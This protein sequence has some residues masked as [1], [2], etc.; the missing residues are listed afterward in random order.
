M[1][2]YIYPGVYIEEVPLWIKPIAGVDTS[3]TGFAGISADIAD[4]DTPEKSAGNFSHVN[5]LVPQPINI[6]QEFRRCFGDIQDVSQYLSLAVHGFFIIGGR[7]CWVIRAI[8]VDDIAD[9]YPWKYGEMFIKH[10]NIHISFETQSCFGE[11]TS[12]SSCNY[13]QADQE[14]PI[15]SDISSTS[16]FPITNAIRCKTHISRS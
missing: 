6:W 9:A 13:T 16:Q 4:A 2:E 1:P 15:I 12:G 3:T 11:L 14:P 7:Y 8:S 10:T 5:A